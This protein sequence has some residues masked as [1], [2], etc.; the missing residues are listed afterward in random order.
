[1]EDDF[2]CGFSLF[3]RLGMSHRNEPCSTPQGAEVIGQLSRIELLTV[4]VDHH[5]RN[6]KMGDD[7]LPNKL[8]DLGRSDLGDDLGLYPFCEVVHR[9]E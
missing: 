3:I 1:M 9:H 2:V 6:S 7:I 4:V 8:P 5:P